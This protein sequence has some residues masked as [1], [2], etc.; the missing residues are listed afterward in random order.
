M[1]LAG[2]SMPIANGPILALFKR[3]VAPEMQGRVFTLIGSLAGAMSPLGLG[4]A[5][6]VADLLGIRAWYIVS[7]AACMLMS[8]VG[9]ST[10]V[11]MHLEDAHQNGSSSDQQTHL[12][13]ANVSGVAK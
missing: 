13:P 5:G 11:F 10:P 1:A 12:P 6:P 7:G 4:M 8:I 2:L 9:F 3:L